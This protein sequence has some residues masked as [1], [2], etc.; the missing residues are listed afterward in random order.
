MRMPA[1]R[2]GDFCTGHRCYP[3]RPSVEGSPDVFTNNR[4]QHRV[5]DKWG[6]HCC[7]LSCHDSE[8]V[9][10]SKTV[11]INGLG[12]ARVGD[13]VACGSKVMTGSHNV[14]IGD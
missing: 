5:T 14:I 6:V 13:P 1:C 10:G 9:S 7:G 2:L 12:A 8:L 11:L 4:P 3:P